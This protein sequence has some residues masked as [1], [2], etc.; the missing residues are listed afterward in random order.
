MSRKISP[1]MKEA[2]L[3]SKSP[4]NILN[5]LSKKCN[6]PMHQKK[7]YC[8]EHCQWL[9]GKVNRC[10]EK[11]KKRVSRKKLSREV[12]RASRLAMKQKMKAN[13]LASLKKLQHKSKSK[14]KAKSKAKKPDL[15]LDSDCYK[16]TR[17]DRKSIKEESIKLGKKNYSVE[18]EKIVCNSKPG[19]TFRKISPSKFNKIKNKIHSGQE[20]T[21][22]E[23]EMWENSC[24]I[25]WPGTDKKPCW[26]CKDMMGGG[27]QFIINPETGRK[28]NINGRLGKKII[29]NYL[30][31]GGFIRAGIRM[32]SCD[33]YQ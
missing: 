4:N 8:P 18:G 30:Q 10:Q 33:V 1:K 25:T 31:A 7:E 17:D 29:N 16:Y 6:Q 24:K 26:C 12:L 32:P 27:Y 20:L 9:G 23:R 13:K 3:S 22:K 21:Q 14:S 19:Y 2:I 15:W 28:V 11:K 5:R